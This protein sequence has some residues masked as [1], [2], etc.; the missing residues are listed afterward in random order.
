MTLVKSPQELADGLA[1]AAAAAFRPLAQAAPEV[2]AVLLERIADGLEALG[3][4]LIS[5]VVAETALPVPRMLGE[6]A[7]TTAQLRMFA[8]LARTDVWRERREVPADPERQPLPRPAL[9]QERRPLGPVLVF[10]A[11]NFPLAFS[12]AGGDTAAAL[13][14][15]CPVIAK[16]HPAHPRTCDLVAGVIDRAV[17][18]SGLPAGSFALFHEDGYALGLALVSH[19]AICAGAFTGSQAGGLA[20]WRAAQSR[21]VPI[22][23]FAEM[24]SVNP[25]FVTP[26]R[27]RNDGERIAEGLQASMVLGVGQFCTQPGLLFVIHDGRAAEPLVDTLSARMQ[28][29]P[30]GTMLTPVLARTYAEACARRAAIAG[31]EC[32]ARGAAPTDPRQAQ[33]LLFGCALATFLAEPTLQEEIFGPTSLLVRC[34]GWADF[35]RA[36]EALKGQLTATVWMAPDEA[37]ACAD[38]LWIL[39]QRAG[40]LVFDGFPTGVEVGV[41]TV[42]GGPFPA[43]TDARYT[44]VGTRAIER[45]VR[46]LAWQSP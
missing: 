11:S 5:T 8:A 45:F 22:P 29:A 35:V 38:L 20:L 36:A 26:A 18:A 17:A 4:T 42:H 34:A 2:R 24:G 46:P 19:P 39:E 9:I 13:A 37:E 6:R 7:R 43:T 23:F 41:A 3:E 30:A 21:P 27:Q 33:A 31:V 16:A 10:G 25:V 1:T 12:V 14:V 28:A 44:S 15:G 32:L 40:R